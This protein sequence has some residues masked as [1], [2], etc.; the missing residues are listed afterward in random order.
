MTEIHF[1]EPAGADQPEAQSSRKGFPRRLDTD[2]F[3]D[4]PSP[5]RQH[6][7]LTMANVAHLLDGNGIEVSYDVISK[8]LSVR[9]GAQDL[10]EYDLI[11]LGNLH[12]MGSNQFLDFIGVV[13]RRNPCNPVADWIRSRPWD[14]KDRLQGLY[15][16]LHLEEDYPPELRDI[17]VYRWLMSAVAAALS[18]KEFHARGVLTLQGGQGIG[19]T[20][21]IARLVPP[22]LQGQWFKRDHHLDPGSKDSVLAAIAHWIAEL[23]ELDS[24]F[25]RDVARL[26]GFITNDRDLIRLPYA[27][28]PVSLERRTVFA[29]SV[30]D[31]RFLVD[32]TG[33]SRWW[34]IAVLRLDYAHEIDMQQVYAQLAIDFEAGMQWWL[35]SDEER[36]LAEINA[37]H[38]V[39]SAVEERL[40]ERLDL[41]ATNNASMTAIEVLRK[42][43]MKHPSNQQCREAGSFLRR[44]FGPP[45][46]VNGRDKWRVALLPEDCFQPVPM[47][48]DDEVY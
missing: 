45:S 24:S 47:D 16:T 29:A 15:A 28:R 30:N 1:P 3:P 17:L 8:R 19:K 40:L 5:G 21:W 48:D 23:G 36:Q 11:S 41:D 33:N 26:K 4:Q 44:Q 13:G 42:I 46:R 12:G 18:A 34:T 2:G 27:A 14:G 20:S 32:N 6:F 31:S 9:Y 7:P 39:K 35:T 22:E 38:E 43:G 37:R 10:E 25:R